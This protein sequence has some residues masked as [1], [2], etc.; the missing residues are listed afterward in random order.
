MTSRASS[1]A[2]VA[3]LADLA[4]INEYFEIRAPDADRVPV[5]RLYTDTALLAGVIE[6]VRTRIGA[7]ERRVAVST[8]FLGFA[9]RLWSVGVGGVIGH[10]ILPDLGSQ[11]L[12]FGETGGA[13]ML[14]LAQPAGWQGDDLEPRLADLVLDEHLEPLAAALQRLG[15]ISP[16]LLRGNAASALLGAANVFDHHRS[17]GSARRLAERLC[18]DRRLAGAIRFSDGGYRRSSCC[19]YYRTRTSGVCGDCVFTC[20]PGT[21]SRKDAS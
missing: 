7:T 8:F 21:P 3:A 4:E 18:S 1:A 5:H 19:L 20:A 14:H 12:S 17:A 11:Q 15:P 9:A 10:R 16:K 6:R 13:I 2:T